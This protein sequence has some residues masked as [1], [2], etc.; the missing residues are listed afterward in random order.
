MI[1][2]KKQNKKL[3]CPL[4][5]FKFNPQDNLACPSCPFKAKCQAICCPNCG[6]QTVV[7]GEFTDFVAHFFPRKKEKNGRA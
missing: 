7:Q 6:Y 1:K 2:S 5:G 4:C 3:V